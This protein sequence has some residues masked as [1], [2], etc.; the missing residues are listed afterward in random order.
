MTNALVADSE[1]NGFRR[2][3]Q[4]HPCCLTASM[5]LPIRKL[6]ME[7]EGDYLQI[8]EVGQGRENDC[9]V[10][11]SILMLQASYEYID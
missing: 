1:L 8:E 4:K 3:W 2:C 7:I 10:L 11:I 5:I 6:K 9:P